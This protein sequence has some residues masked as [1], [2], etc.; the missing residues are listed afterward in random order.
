MK[1]SQYPTKEAEQLAQ[2]FF[3]HRYHDRGMLKWQGFFLSDHTAALNR[4][5][6]AKPEKLHKAQKATEL[7]QR[8]MQA[9]QSQFLVHIQLNVLDENHHPLAVDGQVVGIN[10][11]RVVIQK[12]DH[13]YCQL[14]LTILRNVISEKI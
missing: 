13:H 3:I 12:P 5:E 8:L 10:S 9:W 6:K 11:D 1:V 2:H 7:N 14:P 4:A